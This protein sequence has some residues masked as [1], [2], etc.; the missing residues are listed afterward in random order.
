[1]NKLK[2][3]AIMAQYDLIKSTLKKTNNHMGQ[4]ARIL[5]IDPKTLYNKLS[6][7]SR[8]MKRKRLEAPVTS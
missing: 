1:M 7:Y 4:T 6:Q 3:V 5:E 8:L 2:E